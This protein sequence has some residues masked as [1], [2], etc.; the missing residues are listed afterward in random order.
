MVR[1]TVRH[2]N[3][4]RCANCQTE[5]HPPKTRQLCGRCYSALR[6]LEQA[7][8]VVPQDNVERYKEECQ[9]RLDNLKAIVQTRNPP[10]SGLDVEKL[11]AWLAKKAGVRGDIFDGYASYIESHFSA[12][13]RVVLYG[14][15][16]YI[17][18][19]IQWAGVD[20]GYIWSK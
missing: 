20:W 5:R 11:L 10:I 8:Q 15:L 14:L 9:R 7:E 1:H 12:K 13:N 18:E 3:V 16:S 17:E 4:R 19:D 6:K 2:K